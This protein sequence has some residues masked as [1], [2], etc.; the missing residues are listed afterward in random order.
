MGASA[1]PTPAW[2]GNYLDLSR[3]T[4][5]EERRLYTNGLNSGTDAEAAANWGAWAKFINDQQPLSV[6]YF[7]SQGYA[8][9]PRLVGYAPISIEWLPNVETWY[10]K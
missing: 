7:K 5:A 3:Y 6:I 1:R 9:N 2:G 4:S 10:F 8:V